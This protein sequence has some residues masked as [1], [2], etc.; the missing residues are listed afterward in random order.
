MLR[1]KLTLQVCYTQELTDDGDELRI[2]G[3]EICD[4]FTN[5][6]VFATFFGVGVISS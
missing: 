6:L 1:Y 5:F 4:F 2:I 3:A